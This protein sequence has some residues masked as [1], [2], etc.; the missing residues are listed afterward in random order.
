MTLLDGTYNSDSSYY[1]SFD[2]KNWSPINK[3]IEIPNIDADKI[4]IKVVTG[5]FPHYNEFKIFNQE[6]L[7][8]MSE[9]TGIY[10][11][12]ESS[13]IFGE[14]RQ[15][16]KESDGK[17]VLIQN[18][19]NKIDKF[20]NGNI[21]ATTSAF[22]NVFIL[23]KDGEVYKLGKSYDD[24]QMVSG[25]TN[26]AKI[27]GYYAIDNDNNIWKLKRNADDTYFYEK[28]DYVLEGK[29]NKIEMAYNNQN[30]PVVLY[31]TGKAIIMNQKDSGKVLSN[32]AIDIATNENE[33][34]VLEYNNV[35]CYKDTN[36]NISISCITDK[37]EIPV[38]INNQ[39]IILTNKG[40]CYYLHE[41]TTD[42]D[43]NTQL[44]Y[45]AEPEITNVKK[46]GDYTYQSN[47]NNIYYMKDV[48]AKN[49]DLYSTE[50]ETKIV[51]ANKLVNDIVIT[52]DESTLAKDKVIIKVQVPNNKYTIKL[53]NGNIVTDANT[54][55]EVKEN[56]VYTF[57]F[58]DKQGYTSIR[59][60][61]ITNI[62]SRKETKV[63]EAT[64]V[65]G[66]IKLE[67]DE[68]IEYSLD[69]G[70]N[71]NKY[72]DIIDYSRPIYARV[73]NSEY[74]CSIIKI[75]LNNDGKLEVEN[76]ESRKI[77]GEILTG[78][79]GKA[80]DEFTKEIKVLEATIVN[81]NLKLEGDE[82][83]EY[84]YDQTYW[85]DYSDSNLVWIPY[86]GRYYICKS[87]KWTWLNKNLNSLKRRWKLRN[88]KSRKRQRYTRSN[89][90]RSNWKN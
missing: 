9:I 48:K 56:G 51:Q 82:N 36:N 38:K 20:L 62:Q 89:S 15:Y 49:S 84:S 65:N 80:Q 61:H 57:E 71:W 68:N 46:F 59:V 73:K 29:V 21:L 17:R 14:D 74:E 22:D 16:N 75:T 34:Y 90:Y 66:K 7:N 33:I 69:G 53:P 40:N 45:K 76:T 8:K 26:I 52:K 12:N 28:C 5:S 37:G 3:D 85:Y 6:N 54:T 60:I 27:G 70:E 47:N 72:S 4:Y 24:L 78:G 50:T 31:E 55:Y 13:Y 44:E 30:A 43:T 64:V 35:I 23:K 11:E 19:E 88:R 32:Q 67:G 39:G 10:N 1:Y 86:G 77:Q 81:G 58:T 2:N 25:G 87:K 83:I 18:N 41:Y 63:P 42:G 79:T